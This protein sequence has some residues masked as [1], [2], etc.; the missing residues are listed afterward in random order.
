MVREPW[1]STMREGERYKEDRDLSGENL[2]RQA[3]LP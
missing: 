3:F 1:A 2:R